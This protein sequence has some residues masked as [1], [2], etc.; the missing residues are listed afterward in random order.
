MATATLQSFNLFLTERL[1]AAAVDIFGFVEKTVLEYQEEVQRTR[2][3]NQRLQRLLDLLYQPEVRLHRAD[4]GQ[5]AFPAPTEEHSLQ[6]PPTKE[7]WIPSVG[8]G[9]PGPLPVKEEKQELWTG[10][11]EQQ[12]C[13]DYGGE[14]LVTT[15]GQN[16]ENTTK[17]EGDEDQV[18]SSTAGPNCE[19]S[20]N[21]YTCTICSQD[22]LHKI[23][24]L[25]HTA[26]HSRK[27][28]V[29]CNVCGKTSQTKSD[30]KRHM[31]AHTE[32][33]PHK[34][35]IC[36]NRYKLKSHIK[37]HLRTHTGERPFACYI[38][39]QS[40]NRCTTMSKHA[41]L[42]HKEYKPYRCPQCDER[43][44]VLVV[45]RQHMKSIHDVTLA[46]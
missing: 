23:H 8:Q 9:K 27:N 22:F 12:V 37:E 17:P 29:T 31:K 42:R 30:M 14:I 43:F 5:I 34:C 2:Q 35:P 33:K 39:G 21:T 15:V 40:F 10:P 24:F 32:E 25:R 13:P 26:T 4:S 36:G 45:F 7:E 20:K 44:P 38:C 3:E 28:R 16:A 11:V 1:T 41:R 19:R 46:V 6:T 18:P